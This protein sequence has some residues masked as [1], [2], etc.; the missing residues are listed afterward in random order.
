MN[1][2]TLS[3]Q[4]GLAVR[5]P[6][7]SKR[8]AF[9]LIELLVVIATIMVLA[10]MLLPALAGTQ[11]QSKV[12][13]CE[14]RFRQWA[15]SANLY[16][17]D[18]RSWLP[19]FN[20]F[21]GGEF[22]RSV[23]TNICNALYPYGMD[24]PVWFCPM[25]PAELDAANYW[26]QFGG[27]YG[28]GLG[29]PIH[30]SIELT[31]YFNHSYV[32]ECFL[33]DNYWA[34]RSQGGTSFPVDYSH[35]PQ[36]IWPTWLKNQPTLPTS[37]IYGW[38]QRLHDRTAPYVPFVSDLAGSG[39]GGGLNSPYPGSPSVTNISPN[40]AHFING[41]LIGVNMAFAD[42]RVASHTPDQMRCVYHSATDYWFY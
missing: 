24:V 5:Q 15:A 20:T 42:G 14:A 17:N 32:G 10:V 13:A 4:G 25:R 18:N 29:H 22:A 41:T 8:T 1:A 23:G 6:S 11:S 28:G 39:Q 2:S 7:V 40:T 12:T 36:V 31:E 34:P 26:A 33:N 35:L 16:A 30:N 9:T 19:S 3:P 27:L 37:V 38:P 21:G